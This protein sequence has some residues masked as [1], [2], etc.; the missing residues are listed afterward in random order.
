MFYL[1]HYEIDCINSLC[2]ASD[3]LQ[4]CNLPT[5]V[6]CSWNWFL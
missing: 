5:V 1:S 2:I 4:F 3:V 6:Y